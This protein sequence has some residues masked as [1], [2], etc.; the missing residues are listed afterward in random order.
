VKVALAVLADAANV[1]AD[2]KLNILG[3][4]DRFASERFPAAIA[5]A[6]LVIKFEGDAADQG[7][8]KKL[9]IQLWD[10]DGHQVIGLESDVEIPADAGI[11][12]SFNNVLVMNGLGFPH[13]GRYAFH[14][15]INGQTEERVELE[16][17]L[18]APPA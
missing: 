15:L 2:G 1:T 12:P 5:R 17:E 8:T 18:I 11:R 13:P 10:A 9:E 7:R 3:V 4:F 16:A 6:T 14:I